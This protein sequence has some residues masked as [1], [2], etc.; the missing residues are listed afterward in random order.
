MNIKWGVIPLLLL[1]SNS[2]SQDKKLPEGW[3]VVSLD[4]KTAYMNL[5]TGSISRTYPSKPAVKP[6]EKEAI[7]PT[8]THKV[9]KGET[10]SKIARK[11]G[12][13]LEKLYRLNNVTNFDQLKVGQ[14][15]VIG[16]ADNEG[17]TVLDANYGNT[18]NSNIYH[19]VISKETLYRIALNYN[20]SVNT[21]KELNN[22]ENNTIFI[23]QKLI[24][25]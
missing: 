5:V 1:A 24:V 16:Y 13:G 17:E 3:D 9:K 14:E 2:Y 21:L 18:Q 23:G 20:I 15:I 11:Y 25:K 8:I 7:D 4:D 6:S 10:L 22:L 19:T 12:F